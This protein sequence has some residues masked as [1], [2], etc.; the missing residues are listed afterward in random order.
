MTLSQVK[1]KKKSASII[2]IYYYLREKQE[3]YKSHHSPVTTGSEKRCLYEN[4][5]STPFIPCFTCHPLYIT[6]HPLS[7]SL[8]HPVTPCHPPVIYTFPCLSLQTLVTP[9][10]PLSH[11]LSL[12]HPCSIYAPSIL[13]TL[14]D[15]LFK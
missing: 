1:L 9:C 12:C 2:S 13:C 8:V 10:T 11:H 14:F 3:A 6:C 5:P 7:T 4:S 15:C